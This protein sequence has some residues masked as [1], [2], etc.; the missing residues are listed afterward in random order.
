MFEHLWFKNAKCNSVH[1]TKSENWGSPSVMYPVH[2]RNVI[3]LLCFLLAG[4]GGITFC[5]QS[6]GGVNKRLGLDLPK[7]KEGRD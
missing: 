2:Q 3:P 1:R 4:G 6:R 5:S 7:Q